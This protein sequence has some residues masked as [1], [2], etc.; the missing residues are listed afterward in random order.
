LDSD[1]DI[2][3]SE[4]L[5]EENWEDDL[6]Q[7]YIQDQEEAEPRLKMGTKLLLDRRRFVS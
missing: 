3:T 4:T 5:S 1:N 2:A 6:L 7:H